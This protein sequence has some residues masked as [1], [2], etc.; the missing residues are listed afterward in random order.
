MR[1]PPAQRATP[2]LA[3]LI[4]AA[5]AAAVHA[6]EFPEAVEAPSAF[7]T[8]IEAREY[9]DRFESVEDVLHHA[10]GMRVRRFGGLGA[11]STASIRGAKSEQVLVLMDGVRLNSTLRGGVDLSS[12]SLRTIERIEVIRGGGAARYGSDAMGGVI[13]ITSRAPAQE[14]AVDVSATTGSYETLG[15]DLLLSLNGERV[16][17]SLAYSRLRSQNDFDFDLI[18]GDGGI[19]DLA[20]NERHTRLNADFV[21]ETGLLSSYLDT[22]PTSEASAILR[23]SRK[24]NGQPGGTLGV[25]RRDVT[26]EQLSCVDGEE[27]FRRA[28]F[29]LGWSDRALGPGAFKASVYHRYEYSELH[30]DGQRCGFFP[31]RLFP[32][33]TRSQSTDTQTGIELNYIGEPVRLGRA[34]LVNRAVSSVRIERVRTDDVDSKRR[35]VGN[36]FTQS[37]VRLFGGRL[38]LLPALGLELAD[39]SSGQV[40]SAQF[41]GFEEVDVD[42]GSEWLPQIGA[43][44]RL[45]PGLRLKTNY[46]RAYRRPTFAELFHPDY[47]FIRGNPELEPEQSWNFDVGLEFSNHGWGPLAQLRLEGVFFHRDIE[48]AIEWVQFNNSFVPR[49]T[50]QAEARGYELRGSLTLWNRLELGGNY[51]YLDT[52][53]KSTGNPLPHSPRNQLFGRAALRLAGNRLWVEFTHEDDLFLNAGGRFKVDSATQLDAGI[54]LRPSDLPGLAWVPEN[55]TLSFEWI[56]LTGEQRVDS[57]GLPLPDDTLWY[58]RLRLAPR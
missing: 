3:L 19:Q 48:Q 6:Q 9:D 5:L 25:P 24:D 57:L 54:S 47:G 58:M 50:G 16:R 18:E 55:L 42:D 27:Q 51:T 35:W 33:R 13:S 20:Q 4:L 10:A 17:S 45:A 38:R 44:L 53:I 32:D 52:E 23:F 46:L 14:G 11:H 29:S 21:R 40:R 2:V 34:W 43:I 39:T 7:V 22:G 28:V 36:L 26:D 12:L 31:A 56:N 8:V 30:D 37:E 15:A 41:K 1:S 49:N